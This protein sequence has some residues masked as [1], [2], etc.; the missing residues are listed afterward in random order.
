MSRAKQRGL[1][2]LVLHET[3]DYN[4]ETG[5]I[6]RKSTGKSAGWTHPNGYSYVSLKKSKT[7]K[8]RT[9]LL[10]RVA[11]ALYYNVDPYPFEVDHINRIKSD[12]SI[13]NLRIITQKDQA[14]N[15]QPTVSDKIGDGLYQL[16][17]LT[18]DGTTP[19]GDYIGGNAF[20]LGLL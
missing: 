17:L 20:Q 6:T 9:L 8:A 14:Q 4:P 13:I 19:Q 5:I 10:H 3:F 2:L 11:Y 12:N 15:R 16:R 18:K 7:D 1:P